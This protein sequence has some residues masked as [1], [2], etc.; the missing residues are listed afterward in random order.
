MADLGCN[1]RMGFEPLVDVNND[2][3]AAFQDR[4][5]RGLEEAKAAM[6][7]AQDEYAQYYNHRHEPAP[8]FQPGNLV[9]L[10]ASDICTDRASKK[11]DC[12]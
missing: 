9:L 1:P 3:A 11:L 12:L 10:D 7:Q 5:R 4:M 2:N 6:R 8:V